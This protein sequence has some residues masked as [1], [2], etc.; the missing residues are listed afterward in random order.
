M[1]RALAIL[2]AGSV[3]LVLPGCGETDD[4]E[5][6]SST[7]EFI[8]AGDEICRDAQAEIERQRTTV[9]TPEQVTGTLL[10]VYGEEVSRLGELDPPEDLQDEF[11]PYLDER[12]KSLDALREAESAAARGDPLA[13]LDALSEVTAGQAKRTELAEAVGFR[14]CSQVTPEPG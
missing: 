6:A 12:E 5:P 13:P 3:L 7:D 11:D 8:A 9:A 4:A 2:A 14:V 1:G 10:S